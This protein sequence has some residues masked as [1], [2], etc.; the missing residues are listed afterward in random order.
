MPDVYLTGREEHTDEALSI[1]QGALLA[2]DNSDTRRVAVI[3]TDTSSHDCNQLTAQY[4]DIADVL[5]QGDKILIR[6]QNGIDI[7]IRTEP[8][9]HQIK[10]P[11][12]AHTRHL[13]HVDQQGDFITIVNPYYFYQDQ[14]KV[15][16]FKYCL[17]AP[18]LARQ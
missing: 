8:L 2:P 15:S 12:T 9:L 18:G 6:P 17:H 1:L 14:H 13:A 7:A 5:Q 16:Y 4:Y 11:P 3:R 10:N